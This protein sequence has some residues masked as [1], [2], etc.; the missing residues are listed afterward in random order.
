[1]SE[2]TVVLSTPRLQLRP[3]AAADVETLHAFWTDPDVRKYLWDDE[4]ISLEQVAEVVASSTQDFATHG[5]GHWCATWK[6]SSALVGWCGLRYFGNPPEVEVLYGV[7]PQAWGQGL[8]VEAT[9]AVLAYGFATLGL[10][11]IYA[12]TDPPNK[13]SVRVME[14]V[15]MRFDKRLEINGLAAIYYVLSRDEFFSAPAVA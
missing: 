7:M 10:E 1:M 15:G 4:V 9:R 11:R 3:C 2:D 8:A 14:K 13:A 12:G 6:D 5:F